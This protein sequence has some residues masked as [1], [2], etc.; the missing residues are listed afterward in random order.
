VVGQADCSD[1]SPPPVFDGP[2]FDGCYGVGLADFTPFCPDPNAIP[3]TLA[4]PGDLGEMQLDTSTAPECT[5]HTQRDQ[6][7]VCLLFARDVTITGTL[8][9]VGTRPLVILATHDL[10]VT[11]AGKL[12]VDSAFNM[13]LFEAGASFNDP[14]CDLTHAGM[15]DSTTDYGGGGAGGAF[16]GPGGAGGV[17]MGGPGGDIA[18]P[19]AR[20]IRLRGGCPGNKG[21]GTNQN[22]GGSS[23]GALY[24]IAG[25]MLDVEGAV[26]GGGA[27][28]TL[29]IFPHVVGASAGGSGG[30]LVFEA[31][32]VVLR[33]T[34]FADGGGG[35][36][37]NGPNAGGNAGGDDG[38]IPVS[39]KG[40]TGSGGG[41][42]GGDGSSVNSPSGAPGGNGTLA[43]GGGGGGGAGFVLIFSP[44]TPIESGAITP[45]AQ[46]VNTPL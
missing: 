39:A 9:A 11:S 8:V 23:G 28:G 19:L 27:G 20:P 24:L 21:G 29:G 30:M 42:D 25:H 34:V 12:R 35:S 46:I 18:P 7:T 16:G 41:G 37:G 10:V 45:T 43:A 15:T 36:G 22:A 40:G 6:S 3:A 32:M 31:P 17:G 38:G 14:T 33:G 1:A 13:N 2:P 44:T 4:I 26:L 5:I